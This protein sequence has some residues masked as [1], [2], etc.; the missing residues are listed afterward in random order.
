VVVLGAWGAAFCPLRLKGRIPKPAG[1]PKNPTILE[2]RLRA[3]RMD[4]GLSQR[5]LARQ[6]AVCEDSIR[7]WE[8]GR[9]RIGPESEEVVL[10]YISSTPRVEGRESEDVSTTGGG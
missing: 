5:K 8:N 2:E 7:S 1:Y 3:R 4:D 6:L 9:Y 10:A